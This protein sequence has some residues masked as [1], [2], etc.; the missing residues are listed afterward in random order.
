MKRPP[1]RSRRPSN[2]L[3]NDVALRRSGVVL[4]SAAEGPKSNEHRSVG[5]GRDD[6]LIGK[7]RIHRAS[8]L[9][10]TA[11]EVNSDECIT[12]VKR[13][14]MRAP[15]R[16]GRGTVWKAGPEGASEKHFDASERCWYTSRGRGP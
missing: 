7:I 3:G 8:S 5:L 9:G 1:D 6:A 13:M 15:Y 11:D 4:L 2:A 10:V 14:S 12:H 16:A